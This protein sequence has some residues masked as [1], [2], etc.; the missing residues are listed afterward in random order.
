MATDLPRADDLQADGRA[1]QKSGSP[2]LVLFSQADCQWCERARREYLI[3]MSRDAHL[4]DAVKYRQIDIDSDRPLIDF[5]G[6]TST[7]RNFAKEQK[8]RFAPTLVLYGPSGERLD[9]AIVGMRLPDFYG[10]Y[11]E[12]SIDAA[13]ARMKEKDH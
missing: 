6:Q 11:I 8:I 1:E 5:R 13:R 12:Q 2:I 7:H 10:Q 4:K 9:E 3:P